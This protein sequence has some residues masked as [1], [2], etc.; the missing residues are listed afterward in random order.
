ML[1]EDHDLLITLIADVKWI[2]DNLG[3]HIKHHIRL[4]IGLILIIVAA[5][6][7]KIWM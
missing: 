5:V 7:A 2:K 1:D 3:N 4:E 6:A